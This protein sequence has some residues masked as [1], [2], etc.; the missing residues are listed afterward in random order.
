VGPEHDSSPLRPGVGPPSRV[1]HFLAA[2]GV[3][4]A[5]PIPCTLDRR[6]VPLHLR[7]PMPDRRGHESPS[8]VPPPLGL[9]CAPFHILALH[10][11]PG[12]APRP[13]ASHPHSTLSAL[14]IAPNGYVSQV[15]TKSRSNLTRRV[16]GG[17]NK[18]LASH[19]LDDR[20]IGH[21]L[22]TTSK[23]VPQILLRKSG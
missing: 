2:V 13:R 10:L 7:P 22:G 1:W 14:A 3:T 9:L 8:S 17:S 11:H 18:L 12:A 20:L 5:P 4:C 19:R 6:H 16:R 15:K 21:S 23:I